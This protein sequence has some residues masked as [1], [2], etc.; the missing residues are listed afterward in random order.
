MNEPVIIE[1]RR[2]VEKRTF[3]RGAATHTDGLAGYVQSFLKE[4][5]SLPDETGRAWTVESCADALKIP[6]PTLRRWMGAD[7][8]EPTPFLPNSRSNVTRRSNAKAAL[9]DPDQRRAV[10][11]SLPT[12][13]R[14]EVRADL[15]YLDAPGT[16]QCRHCSQH[17]P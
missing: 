2:L 6:P 10:L 1:A 9:A 3:L 8:G 5:G 15:L 14:D 4:N 16:T 11:E 7:L 13:V 17:C 12:D